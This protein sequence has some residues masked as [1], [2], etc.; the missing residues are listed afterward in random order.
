MHFH[1]RGLRSSWQWRPTVTTV[2][3]LAW[4]RR[5]PL[6]VLML[7]AAGTAARELHDVI[8]HHMS[9]MGIQAAAARRVLPTRPN[10]A[11]KALASIGG[12]S[13]Q[14]VGKLHRMVVFLRQDN[15][16]DLLAPPPSLRRLDGRI[17]QLTDAK[18]AVK[19]HV[20]GDQQPLPGSVDL[21]T[22]RVVQEALITTPKH[23]EATTAAVILRYRDAVFEVEVIDNGMGTAATTRVGNGRERHGL[24]G[25][26]ERVALHRGQFEAGSRAEG[27]FGLRASFPLAERS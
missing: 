19:V 5:A 22:Y 24:I 7:V 18:L 6:T 23:A 3:P 10:Q 21:P 4:R 11:A 12:S 13:R 16:D 2:T 17:T 9:L 25:M 1:L 14:A 26:R 27:G 20:Q 15:E 8:A